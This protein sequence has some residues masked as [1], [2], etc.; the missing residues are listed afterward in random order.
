MFCGIS[1]KRTTNT[2]YSITLELLIEDIPNV[3]L[4]VPLLKESSSLNTYNTV[5]LSLSKKNIS[6][7]IIMTTI[8]FKR[9]LSQAGNPNYSK[10]LLIL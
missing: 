9:T 10:F 1:M 2:I 4:S 3:C 8:Q 6:L 5:T 7:T